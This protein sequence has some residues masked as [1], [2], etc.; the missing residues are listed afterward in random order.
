M[1]PL[2]IAEA[3][4]NHNGDLATAIELINEAAKSNADIIK[5]QI[6]DSDL[7]VTPTTQKADYQKTTINN[8]P[9]QLSMLK[10]LELTH[11]E[12]IIIKQHCINKN[13]EF[14]ATAFDRISLKFLTETLKV[15]WLKIPSGE[16]TNLPFIMDHAKEEIPLIIST[17]MATYE[18]IEDAITV[19]KYSRLYPN[20]IPSSLHEMRSKVS[21][22]QTPTDI[23]LLHCTTSYPTP[24]E[25]ANLLAMQTLGARF[26]CKVGYS[27]H[28]QGILAPIVAASLGATIIEKHITLDKTQ[29]GP[30]HSSSIDTLELR[31]MITKITETC[32]LLGEKNK[33]IS[34]SEEKNINPA[35]KSIVAGINIAKGE[36]LSAHNL[37][38][39]RPGTG[40]PPSKYWELLNTKASRDYKKNDHI[41]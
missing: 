28:T 30:D 22:E 25:E 19:I 1:T 36:I 17:G 8:E 10:E 31:K 13:I 4:V 41:N 21:K 27:D 29:D 37:T 6:F 16:L 26:G 23:T 2:I 7:L 5:F 33:T 20:S 38:C 18:N 24:F 11:D 12:F 39:K 34:A 14:L 32:I 35:R 9:D 15:N 40:T 3:G